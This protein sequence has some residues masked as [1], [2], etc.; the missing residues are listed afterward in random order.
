M[1]RQLDLLAPAD[2]QLK[3]RPGIV[4]PRLWVRRLAIRSEPGVLIR[5]VSLRPGLNVVWSPDS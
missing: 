2:L 3:A 1:P 5:D 4:Q